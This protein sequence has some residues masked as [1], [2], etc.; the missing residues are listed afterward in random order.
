MQLWNF[1]F[2]L[3][4]CL[5][6]KCE[7]FFRVTGLKSNLILQNI[8]F[9]KINYFLANCFHRVTLQAILPHIQQRKVLSI[10]TVF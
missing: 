7:D 5:V 8:V 3:G 6:K 9:M 4:V 2:T 10:V 1:P